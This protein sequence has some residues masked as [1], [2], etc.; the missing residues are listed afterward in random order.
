[1]A[2][3]EIQWNSC[4][5]HL[6]FGGGDDGDDGVDVPPFLSIK[7]PIAT[8][9]PIRKQRIFLLSTFTK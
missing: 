2:D 4:L 8:S 5:R 6:L 1:M 7:P 3:I 9:T